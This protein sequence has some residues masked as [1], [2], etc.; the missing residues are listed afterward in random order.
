[1]QHRQFDG[2]SSG[3]YSLATNRPSHRSRVKVMPIFE[4]KCL[5]CETTFEHLVLPT[6]D[7]PAACPKCR[8]KG[9]NLEQ[10]I[11]M[12]S[13]K[14]EYATARQRAWVQKESKNMQYEQHQAE[15]RHAHDHD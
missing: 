5:K 15:K 9:K 2:E 1:L 11:S 13:T 10:M 4:Y 7:D 6:L 8:A 3:D 12:F 14:N